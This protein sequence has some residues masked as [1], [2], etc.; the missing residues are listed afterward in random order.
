MDIRLFDIGKDLGYKGQ[1]LVAFVEKTAAEIAKKVKEDDTKARDDRKLA[2]EERQE[3][4]ELLEKKLELAR[5]QGDQQSTGNGNGNDRRYLAPSPKLPRF[6]EGKDNMDAYLDRF[7][8]YAQSQGWP[9]ATWAISLSALLQ[10]KALD[11]YARLPTDQVGEYKLVK[12]A[13]LKRF[14]L[15]A[16]DFRKKFRGSA[17]EAGE[18]PS[19]FV[20]RLD[21]YLQRWVELSKCSRTF[22]GLVDLLLRQQLVEKGGQD[23]S[24]FLKERKLKSVSEMVGFA[25][26]F[27]EAHGGRGWSSKKPYQDVRRQKAPSG[28]P[29]PKANSEGKRGNEQRPPPSVR[30]QVGPCFICNQMG[31][32]ASRCRVRQ[33]SA[34]GLV[35]NPPGPL[36]GRRRRRS[37]SPPEKTPDEG[38]EQSQSSCPTCGDSLT[39]NQEIGLLLLTSP[40]FTVAASNVVSDKLQVLCVACQRRWRNQLPVVDGKIGSHDVSILRDTGCSGVVVKK[41]LVSAGQ[42]T[43]QYKQCVLID[44]TVRRFPTAKVEI[45]SPIFVGIAEALCMDSP[46]FDVILGNIAGVRPI[47]DPLPDWK[48]GVVGCPPQ[49]S[50][51][52]AVQTRA[53]AVQAKRPVRPLKVPSAIPDV[54]VEDIKEAQGNDPTLK[55]ARELASASK[56]GE[57]RHGSYVFDRGLLYRIFEPKS[58]TDGNLVRQ[59]VVPRP[60]RRTV[61]KLA[62]EGT[63]GGHQGVKKVTEKVRSNFFWPGVQADVVRFC[64]SCDI[65]QRT[66]SKGRIPKVQIG[67]VPVIDTPF[68]RVAVDLIGPI[69]PDG[70]NRFCIHCRRLNRTTVE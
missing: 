39:P 67:R 63:L 47:D 24:L 40:A 55:K 21:H 58:V 20:V 7:E 43:G 60:Y 56:V 70:S 8:R 32:L 9:E 17:P 54:S 53:Q 59:L 15:T 50:V 13:L 2:R 10:G 61:L 36:R 37:K 33:Q 42:F 34:M 26:M 64:R 52:M 25:D 44:G 57:I 4:L 31:H 66:V 23:L 5:L 22:D 11:V 68:R 1:E 38:E 49:E 12:E 14:E 27:V 46:V 30:R 62:H 41:S 28:I 51:G 19:Q 6:D 48:S 16:E 29:V 65:C 18:T 69:K 3:E 35:S 45:K